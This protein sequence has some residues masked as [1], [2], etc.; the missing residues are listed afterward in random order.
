MH[1]QAQQLRR[2]LVGLAVAVLGGGLAVA[3]L[4]GRATGQGFLLGG[5]AALIAFWMMARGLAKAAGK[6]PEQVKLLLMRQLYLRMII[7][8]ALFYLAWQLDPGNYHALLAA[9]LGFFLTRSLVLV[10]VVTRRN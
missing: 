5:L 6:E 8:A 1:E 3:A 2:W 4:Y 7:Y 10:A 9:A